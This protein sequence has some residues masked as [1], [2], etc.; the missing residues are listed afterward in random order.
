MGLAFTI[1]PQTFICLCK[2]ENRLVSEIKEKDNSGLS[3]SYKYISFN[4]GGK[5]K[6]LKQKEE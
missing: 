2:W 5:K 4:V 6:N 1:F 3:R